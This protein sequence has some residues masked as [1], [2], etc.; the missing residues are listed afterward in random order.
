MAKT[1]SFAEQLFRHP[2][3]Y[4]AKVE[5]LNRLNG[6]AAFPVAGLVA[7]KEVLDV[8]CGSSSQHY[9]ADTPRRRTGVDT[10]SEM[11]A[12]ARRLHPAGDYRVGSADKLPFPDK[13]FD[14][15]LLLF[16]LHHMEPVLWAGALAEASRVARESVLV[17]DHVKHE[18]A[19]LGGVQQAWWDAADGGSIYRRKGDWDRVLSD[20]GLMVLDYR[21]AGAMFGNICFFHL[22]P[23]PIKTRPA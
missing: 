22:K 8:G 13:S 6:T 23:A 20:A 17:L 15:A 21:R 1:A 12:A 19:L 16:V 9:P 14:A 2:S 5:F 18:S 7:G 11:V 10:S 4:T 3:L